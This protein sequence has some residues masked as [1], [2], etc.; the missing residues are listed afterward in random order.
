MLWDIDK[1]REV[2]RIP[3]ANFY[4]ARISRL[5]PQQ[6]QAIQEE[7]RRHMEG[8]DIAVAGWI[9]G[10]DW[11][12]TPFQFI[13]ED[14][15]DRDFDASRLL[16]GILVWVTLMEHEDFWGFMRDVVVH[17]APVASMTYFRVTPQ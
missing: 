3:H 2:S 5:S 6:F 11:T 13:Y 1:Q 10:S 7:I 12:G 9:P 15:C 4:N 8:D 17:D 16:F 14:A